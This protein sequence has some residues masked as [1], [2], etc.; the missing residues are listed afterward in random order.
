MIID[1]LASVIRFAIE[2]LDAVQVETD[3]E[4]IIKDDSELI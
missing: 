2:D 4:E 3:H 1:Q